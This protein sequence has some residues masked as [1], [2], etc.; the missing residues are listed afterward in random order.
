M[1][2]ESALER[3]A[4]EGSRRKNLFVG[5]VKAPRLVGVDS[6]FAKVQTEVLR[7]G[8]IL[9][10]TLF[11]SSSC[12][13]DRLEDVI[14]M[15]ISRT[16]KFVRA[17]SQLHARLYLLIWGDG[18]TPAREGWFAQKVITLFFFLLKTRGRFRFSM[19]LFPLV[20]AGAHRRPS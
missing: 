16:K 17:T 5:H 4:G 18:A 2:S 12:I 8:L 1:T 9:S 6:T 3:D 14:N 10:G 7:R 20:F 19:Y 15:I 11:R 13:F